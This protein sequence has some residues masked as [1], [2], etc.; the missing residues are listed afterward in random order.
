MGRH[1]LRRQHRAVLL[2]ELV[3]ADGQ[4]SSQRPKASAAKIQGRRQVPGDRTV[5]PAVRAC[6]AREASRALSGPR[7][8]AGRTTH[9]KT[10]RRRTAGREQGRTIRPP[11][12]A[13]Q[14]SNPTFLPAMREIAR[15]APEPALAGGAHETDDPV[16]ASRG[17]A[18]AR[19]PGLIA[20]H[21]G[22][23]SPGEGNALFLSGSQTFT[24]VPAAPFRQTP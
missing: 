18:P 6:R 7:T 1:R 15:P 2:S 20:A 5:P 8:A 11:A 24:F 3:V 17:R 13:P 21:R 23:V 10:Y 9:A 12:S 22:G 19:S 14:H 16:R 4:H